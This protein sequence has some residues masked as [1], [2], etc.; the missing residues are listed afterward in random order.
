VAVSP[1]LETSLAQ[2]ATA[3]LEMIGRDPRLALAA[4]DE[5]VAAA[6]DDQEACARSTAHRAAGLALRELG[7]LTTAEVRLR[8]AVRVAS[9]A[10]DVTRAAEA[11]MSLAF[12]LLDRGRLRAALAEADHAA[13]GLD[14]LLAVRV[15]CQRALIMQ[16]TG[17][18]DEAL[19]G[20]AAALPALRKAGDSLWQARVHNNRGLLH[21]HRGSL[22]AAE[23]DFT[24]ACA[25]YDELGMD[26]LVAESECN[27]GNVAALRGD[28]PSA[29]AS[30]DRAETTPALRHKPKPQLL[31][32]R[33]QALLS[34]GLFDEARRTAERAVAELRAV[35]QHAD[36]AEAQLWLAEAAA[37]HGWPDIAGTEAR[38]AYAAFVRQGRPGWALLA[39]LVALRASE[40]DGT[41]PRTLLRAARACAAD[42]A[43]AGWRIA[44]LD[45]CLIAARAA[46][47]GQDVATAKKLLESVGRVRRSGSLELRVRGWH[48]R[49]LLRDASGDRRGTLA[50]LRA[51]LALLE[52]QQAV[53]GATEFRVHVS[54][55]GADLAALG[56]DLAIA[57]GDARRVLTWAERWRGRAM[58]LRPVKPPDDPE[59]A[60]AL[61]DLRQLTARQESSRLAGGSGPTNAGRR[62][63]EERVVRASRTARSPLHRPADSPPTPALLSAELGDATL[64]EFVLR[65]RKLFAVI[66]RHGC[67]RFRYVASL[68]AV[69]DQID[70]ATAALRT[71]AFAFGTARGRAVVRAAMDSAGQRLDGLLFD[72][73]RRDLDGRRLVIVPSGGLH[74][75]PWALLPSLADRPVTVAPSAASW[76][77]AVRSAPAAEGRAVF[78]AGPGLPAARA[79][80]VAIAERNQAATAL[81]DRRATVRAVLAA[82]DGAGLAHIAAHGVLRTDNPLLSALELADGPLTVYDLEHLSRAPT[83]VILPACQSGV[84]AVSAGDEMI[85]LVSALLTLGTRTVIAAGMPISDVETEPL[86]LALHER[87]GRGE[88]PAEALVGARAAADP[89]DDGAVAVASSFVCFGA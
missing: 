87:L 79:E 41:A 50:A 35:G 81:L 84:A 65:D 26:L 67:C 55:F 36:L 1:V 82:L 69:T 46:L 75:V 68:A 37:A 47:R 22:A 3:A 6:A 15:A 85:G 19:A 39:R 48:A 25:L 89:Q 21:A 66:L 13:A 42:L 76:L 64:V 44:E 83:T 51:G 59:L 18:L 28:A 31:L 57:S 33:C 32:N 77:N 62:A 12:V 2:R 34:V 14:G 4:A 38:A 20:Y 60:D 80:V 9:R 56:L 86:M 54:A 40:L 24:R 72:P 30:Y 52:Q 70:T 16:R 23:A 8:A 5:V 45:A 58:R 49:A 63:A 53:L 78:A 27:R 61:A 17:R 43:A 7:D 74:A 88:P 73:L 71:L 29:L 10:G 11:R